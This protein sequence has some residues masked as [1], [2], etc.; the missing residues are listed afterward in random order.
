MDSSFTISIVKE[1]IVADYPA[2]LPG[3][4]KNGIIAVFLALDN[5]MTSKLPL[6]FL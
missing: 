5:N 4:Y 2:L 1:L 3:T 6:K